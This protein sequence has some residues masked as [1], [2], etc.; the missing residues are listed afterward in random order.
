MSCTSFITE[1]NRVKASVYASTFNFKMICEVYNLKAI[2]V[3][4][5]KK[6]KKK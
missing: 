5:K 3:K 2:A 1:I 4:L 6:K